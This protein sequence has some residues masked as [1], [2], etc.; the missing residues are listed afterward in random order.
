MLAEYFLMP[1]IGKPIPDP[2][3]PMLMA[4]VLFAVSFVLAIGEEAGWSGYVIGGLRRSGCACVQ[5]CP[6]HS[7]QSRRE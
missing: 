2:Q 1:L 5:H 6:G 4:P 3:F 7:V